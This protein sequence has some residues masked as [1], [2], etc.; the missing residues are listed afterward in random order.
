[1]ASSLAPG[2]QNNKCPAGGEEQFYLHTL[3]E[4]KFP[5]FSTTNFTVHHFA[6]YLA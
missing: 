6:Y 2:S 5:S 4:L 3:V 1:M